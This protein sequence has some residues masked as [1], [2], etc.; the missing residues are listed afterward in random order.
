MVSLLRLIN[1][2]SLG[3]ES[4]TVT[5]LN[6]QSAAHMGGLMKRAGF[7]FSALIL[8]VGCGGPPPKISEKA[9]VSTQADANKGPAAVTIHRTDLEVRAVD[10]AKRILIAE[11]HPYLSAARATLLLKSIARA[12]PT[13]KLKVM[14]GGYAQ[15]GDWPGAV[16]FLTDWSRDGHLYLYCGGYLISDRWV[17]TAAHC[18]IQTTDTVYV[19]EL[20]LTKPVSSPV[21]VEKICDHESYD[22]KSHDFDIA[23]VKLR[24]PVQAT[25]ATL[26]GGDPRWELPNVGAGIL[27][28]GSLTDSGDPSNRLYFAP[29]PVVSDSDCTASYPDMTITANMI[30][31]GRKDA[32][33]AAC[34]GDSG[35]PL[36]AFQVTPGGWLQIGVISGGE[37]C[38]SAK[39]Y[40]VY[41]RVSRFRQWID[42][43]LKG[44][45]PRCRDFFE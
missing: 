40:G 19:G 33:I 37:D 15:Q 13:I 10:G 9:V 20:D 14:G 2:A 7:L 30:C 26:T 44:E 32:G 28:Y 45:N 22:P 34:S 17:L 25:A 38:S 42:T 39:N 29:L 16:A 11:Q 8:A 4:V 3:R 5:R 24:Q 27:G 12:Q 31:A 41:T 43:T 18:P 21:G 6:R 36:V 35:G 1:R 23:L